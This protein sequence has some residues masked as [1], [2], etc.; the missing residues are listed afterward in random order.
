[1][2]FLNF[3][4][5]LINKLKLP[6][7]VY[8]N[9]GIGIQAFIINTYLLKAKIENRKILLINLYD[10]RPILSLFKLHKKNN[11]EIFNLESPYFLFSNSPLFRNFINVL[12]NIFFLSL[13]LFSSI[14]NKIFSKFLC[15]IKKEYLQYKNYATVYN[16]MGHKSF[17]RYNGDTEFWEEI[18]NFDYAIKLNI[19]KE[20]ETRN[21]LQK[22]GL[23]I[24]AWFIC[25]HVRGNQWYQ[26]IENDDIE[27]RRNASIV[28]FYKAFE[29]ITNRGGY[30][31]RIGDSSMDKIKTKNLKIIDYA[32]S[33]IKSDFIDLFL[34]KNC[35]F[36]LCTMS[37]PLEVARL[38]HKPIAITNIYHSCHWYLQD[39][40][41]IGI[42]KHMEFNNIKLNLN[43]IFQTYLK[44]EPIDFF[45]WVKLDKNIKYFENTNDE[46]YDLVLEMFDF[47]E[48]KTELS[49]NQI[50]LNNLI[51]SVHLEVLNKEWN[52][53]KDRINDINSK[54]QWLV[55]NG[56]INGRLC[57]KFILDNI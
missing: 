8:C 19:N 36:F 4:K 12:F 24:N 32:N 55:W 1:M 23:P 35:K 15:I 26:N 47:L 3:K 41:C 14:I 20:K 5:K 34:I 50:F 25:V 10:Y 38:F 7:L 9:I 49:T 39:K 54:F 22:L 37:G 11:N 51:K 57:N 13:F 33:D 40:N 42:M 29:E 30:V 27:N 44:L 48:S 21:L 43:T 45:N 17:I 56:S 16:V 31:V 46:I 52:F 53:S 2:F 6:I 28:N 18:K